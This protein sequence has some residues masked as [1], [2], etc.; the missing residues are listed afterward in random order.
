MAARAHDFREEFF[1]EEG[2]IYLDCATQGP[3]PRAGVRAIQQ[4][5]EWKKTPELLTSHEHYS[6]FPDRARAL[7]AQLIGAE[8][9][10]IALTT[11][12]SDGINAVAQ[13]LAW[14]AGD[15]IVLPA[16]EFPANYFPWKWLER[17]GVRVVEVRPQGRFTTE[18]DLLAALSPRT[19][20]VTMSLVSYYAALR[21]DPARLA[22]VCRERGIHLLVDASQAAG[23]V[24]IDAKHLG[25]S[26]LVAA[27]YKW[28]LAPYGTGFFYVRKDLVEKL[29]LQRI[30][31]QAIEGAMDFNR[32]PRGEWRLAP[33]AR[34]WDA[35]E[36]AN[37][38]NLAG[39]SASLELLLRV[40]VE[41]IERHT[42]S[43]LR[44]L[45]ERLPR[46]RCVLR[47]PEEERRRGTFLSIAARTPET[48]AKL[49]QRL[50]ERKIFV[51]LRQDALRIS[52]HI[53]NVER[54]MDELLAVLGE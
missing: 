30:Y 54:E 11:G 3:L 10:E 21:L 34:R 50:H 29:E 25:V 48:T 51:A 23:A 13:G 26:F 52:P 16:D 5:L 8:P 18:D 12:A 7:L 19:R 22:P 37:F 1:L 14:Q 43:L 41:R 33:D 20:L 6:E 32:L 40:G 46:D 49:W 45:V 4:A 42:T 47:S 35:A 39:L 9:A 36:T 24:P 38:L 27:G 44:Y 28:L 2:R 31:W 15:E 17:R 53:Y